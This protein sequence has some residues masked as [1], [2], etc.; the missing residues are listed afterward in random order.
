MKKPGPDIAALPIRDHAPM[1]DMSKKII[2]RSL[3]YIPVGGINLS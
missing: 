2:C 3:T 1:L